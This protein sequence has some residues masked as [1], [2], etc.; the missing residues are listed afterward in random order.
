MVVEH[1]RDRGQEV[2]E[3][4]DQPRARDRVAPDLAELLVRQRTGLAKDGDVD[5]DLAD[6]VQRT[7]QPERLEP[8]AR[9]AES[10]G[11]RLREER[12]LGPSGREET[13][14]EPREQSRRW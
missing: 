13:D 1:G 9:P 3:A 10:D 7:T 5:G 4:F 2:V 6:V 14:P 12:S 11:E 8:L